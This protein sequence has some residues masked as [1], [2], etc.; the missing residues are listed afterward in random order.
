MEF[1]PVSDRRNF[2][3]VKDPAFL[4]LQLE[5]AWATEHGG[6]A[7]DIEAEMVKLESCDLLLVQTPLW[8]FAL[9][10]ILKGWFDRVLAMGRMY[11]HGGKNEPGKYDKGRFRGKRVLLSLTTGGLQEIFLPDGAN[12]D[13]EAILRPIHRGI[14]QFTGFD[15]LAPQIHY[16]PVRV[17][18]RQRQAWLDAYAA[19]L[20]RIADE[21]PIDVG[22]Y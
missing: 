19:R 4:K 16:G 12:G 20:A 22:R 18:D 9:P 10:A 15:V 21:A 3:T 17:D 2:T 11:G 7:G 6:F 1:N 14:F 8:W 13:I 5:E